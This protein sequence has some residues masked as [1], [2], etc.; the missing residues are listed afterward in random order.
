MNS[1]H[2][3]NCLTS[4]EVEKIYGLLG[5]HPYLTHLAYYRVLTGSQKFLLDYRIASGLDG[6]F[7][8]HLRAMQNRLSASK[9]LFAALRRIIQ[10]NN[11][12]H[13][14]V[15]RLHSVG[16]VR[17]DGGLP[18]PANLLYEMFFRAI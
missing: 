3:P 7:G 14:L 6:P 17:F 1:C 16:L 4:D 12:E 10:G 5:G 9:E 11:A 8:D 2:T 15:Q 13:E 18:K